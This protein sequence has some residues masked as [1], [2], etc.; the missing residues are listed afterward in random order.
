MKVYH[1]IENL[2]N[3]Y[4]GPAKSVPYLAKG[5]GELSIEN[6][7]LSV[8]TNENSSNEVI[9]KYNLSW[10]S[11]SCKFFN[12]LKFSPK[13]LNYI[14]LC[15]NVDKTF[16]LH[17][18]NLWNFIAFL[19][20]YFSKRDSIYSIISVRGSLYGW[21]L[22][23]SYLK[24]KIAWFLFQ[25]KSLNKASC[26]HVTCYE[27]LYAV[28]SLGIVSPIAIVPN[29]INIQE[30]DNLGDQFL[31]KRKL[32]LE[33]NKNYVLFL[34]RIHPKKGLLYLVRAFIKLANLY[35]NW[36]LLIVGP[37]SDQMY[38]DKVLKL[39]DS[40]S[41]N[42]RVKFTGIV[43]GHLRLSYFKC[44]SLFV[45]PSHSEN[46]GI[47]IAEAM[48]AKIPVITTRE[49]P[50]AEILKYDAG[51]WV[52][53]S[54]RNIDKALIEAFK[55]SKSQLNEKGKNGHKLIKRYKWK[56]QCFKMK[57]VYDW[58]C[59]GGTKPDHVNLFENSQN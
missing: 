27:E 8:Q 34:S 44:S 35:S 37:V 19:A 55:L 24:K 58:V 42:S 38:F 40:S 57:Q 1:I 36:D 31:N 5:L 45:L 51:W 26:V 21:S 14:N 20:F 49:T 39:I 32:G 29:G 53:L 52:K 17:S 47:C 50:W 33:I 4:G 23:Q 25:K 6:T 46:F 43:T 28:R 7:L 59:Y 30:F 16:I 15:I 22:S 48:A 54:Q 10:Y 56:H 3:S 2:D 18:H 13:L 11:F 12:K 41:L 9:L